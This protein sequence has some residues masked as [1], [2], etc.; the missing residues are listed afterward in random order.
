MHKND[1]KCLT[2]HPT[3]TYLQ[4]SKSNIDGY[5]IKLILKFETRLR[6]MQT[7]LLKAQ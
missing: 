2:I 7:R 5:R 3:F 6:T 4:A 1:L